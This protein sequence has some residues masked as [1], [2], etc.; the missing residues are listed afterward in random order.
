MRGRLARGGSWTPV[1][2]AR[3]GAKSIDN[4]TSR[5]L[6][7]VRLVDESTPSEHKE[8]LRD[9]EARLGRLRVL[10]L[11]LKVSNLSHAYRLQKQGTDAPPPAPGFLLLLVPKKEREFLLGDLEEEYRTRALRD[12]RSKALIWHWRQ[13]GVCICS[14]A[15]R[16][17]K[18][19]AD[20][21]LIWRLLSR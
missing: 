13:V 2:F 15:W 18:K 10:T 7:P 11:C 6:S 4:S 8:P 12:G 20:A 5:I 19:A 1:A 9:M 3:K 21:G 16:L 14:F 17:L